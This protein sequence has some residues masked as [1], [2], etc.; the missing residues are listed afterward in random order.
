MKKPNVVIDSSVMVIAAVSK[1]ANYS[2][3]LLNLAFADKLEMVVSKKILYELKEVFTRAKFAG[4]LD[5]KVVKDSV[6]KYIHKVKLVDLQPDF[7]EKVKG[8][9]CDPK[10]D[11]FLALADQSKVNYLTTL[12]SADLL[13]LNRWQSVKIARPVLICAEI[14]S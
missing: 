7:L 8:Y 9:C 14:K 2:I 3:D 13:I 1:R 6:K 10:D 5:T 11:I 12:D 4:L